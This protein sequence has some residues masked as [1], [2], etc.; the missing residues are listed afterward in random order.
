MGAVQQCAIITKQ[1]YE[2]ILQ[3]K[4]GQDRDGLIRKIESLLAEREQLLPAITPPF[5]DEEKQLGRKIVEMNKII[6]KGLK[7]IKT[8]IE[9]DILE[10]KKKETSAR[11]YVNPYESLVTD[12]VYYDK[13]K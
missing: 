9:A 4:K 6:D 2:L 3:P 13:K 8:G 10:T 12:G 1:L 7:K 5:T 11:K